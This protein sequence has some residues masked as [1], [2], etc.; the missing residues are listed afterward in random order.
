MYPSRHSR[1]SIVPTTAPWIFTHHSDGRL[2]LFPL[3]WSYCFV[4]PFSYWEDAYAADAVRLTKNALS[5]VNLLYF[6][7]S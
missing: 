7:L 4:S 3:N 6:T 5:A 2:F 1:F